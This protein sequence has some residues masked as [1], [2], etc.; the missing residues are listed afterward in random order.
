MCVNVCMN[1][2]DL[3]I[4]RSFLIYKLYGGAHTSGRFL[5]KD[6]FTLTLMECV[7]I[8]LSE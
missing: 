4:E 1:E 2:S 3:S 6:C 7:K 8:V 5:F